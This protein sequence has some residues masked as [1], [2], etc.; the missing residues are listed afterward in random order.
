MQPVFN[1]FLQWRTSHRE[2]NW[3]IHDWRFVCCSRRCSRRPRSAWRRPELRLSLGRKSVR[4]ATRL[5][6]FSDIQLS[7]TQLL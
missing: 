1:I 5:T 3:P 7:T 2:E 6:T 4:A